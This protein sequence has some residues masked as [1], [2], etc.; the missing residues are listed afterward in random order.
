M[1]IEILW[2]VAVAASYLFIIAGTVG[3]IILATKFPFASFFWE[4]RHTKE[5]FLR[6]NGYTIWILSWSL[7]VTGAAIQFLDYVFAYS[8]L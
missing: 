8:S 4:L 3:L 6:L 1:N 5:S 7:I 2:K